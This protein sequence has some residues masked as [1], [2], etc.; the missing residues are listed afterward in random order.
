M[1][2]PTS[3]DAA[4]N[5]LRKLL[6][7]H[8]QRK[9]PPNTFLGLPIVTTDAPSALRSGATLGTLDRATAERV[10]KAENK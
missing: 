8:M 7:D 2:N 10:V 3:L 6:A 4:E 1:K 5:H 9:I